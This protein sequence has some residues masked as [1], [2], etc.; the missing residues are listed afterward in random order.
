MTTPES[1]P[2]KRIYAKRTTTV[3]DAWDLSESVT[4]LIMD[5][6]MKE[7][8]ILHVIQTDTMKDSEWEELIAYISHRTSHRQ[9][10]AALRPDKTAHKPSATVATLL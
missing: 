2:Q 9:G 4:A 6:R 3:A 1:E 5:G 8:A 7:A 10:S